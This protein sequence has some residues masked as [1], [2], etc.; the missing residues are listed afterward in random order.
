MDSCI[1]CKIAN[2][3]VPAAK[4]YE[5]DRVIAFLDMHPMTEGHTLVVPK[6][7][8][9]EFIEMEDEDATAVALAMK[10]VGVLIKKTFNPPRVGILTKGFDVSHTHVQL[11]PM[12]DGHDIVAA[13]YG[14]HFP[15]AV[16]LDELSAV[17]EK[18]RHSA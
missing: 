18:M 8:S 10:K 11:F 4:V 7:H 15:P 2:G 9:E 14:P 1:F 13:K 16:T 5:D 12:M 6:A 3:E 17:A